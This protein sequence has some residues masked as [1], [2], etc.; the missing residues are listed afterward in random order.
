MTVVIDASA[1]IA[2]ALAETDNQLIAATRRTLERA[3]QFAPAIMPVEVV[4]AIAMAEW[5][6]RRSGEDTD[7]ALQLVNEIIQTVELEPTTDFGGLSSLC[8]RFRLRGADACY[9]QLS[10]N[11]GAALLTSD[12]AL[13]TAALAAGVSLVYDPTA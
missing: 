13:A 3:D 6:G 10:L 5:I 1:I 9:L 8:R 2:V 7:A 12:K 11:H 4:G